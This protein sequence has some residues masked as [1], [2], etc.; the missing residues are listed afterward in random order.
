MNAIFEVDDRRFVEH[1]ERIPGRLRT[2][3]RASIT[4]LTDQLLQ[5][6]RAAEPSRTGRLRGQ[7]QAFVDVTDDKVT[8]RVRIMGQ[9][10]EHNVAAG[11]LEYGAHRVVNVRAHQEHLSHVFN[12]A[13]D[14]QFVAVRAYTRKANIRAQ[15]FLRDPAAA[16]RPR[17]QAELERVIAEQ[18]R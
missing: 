16:M 3:L 13:T 8:G 15:R 4:Q 1:L 12:R 10:R 5:R 9:G 2:A 14:S 7:T 11:A 17:I 18:V 6:I